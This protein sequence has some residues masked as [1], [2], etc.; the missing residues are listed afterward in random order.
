MNDRSMMR[1]PAASSR[2]STAATFGTSRDKRATHAVMSDPS[3][4]D[5]GTTSV[6]PATIVEGPGA[7]PEQLQ[8][9]AEEELE[10]EPEPEPEQFQPE[11]E[12]EREENPE[13]PAPMITA[14]PRPISMAALRGI[15][16]GN[17]VQISGPP[18]GKSLAA[19]WAGGG[20]STA[21]YT[22][23]PTGYSAPDFE[24]N[25][26]L[27]GTDWNAK[28]TLKTAANEGTSGSF[29]TSAGTHKTGT[30]EGGKDLY[31]KYTAA[32]SNL[33]KVGEQEHCDDYAE[34][35]KISLKEA[36]TIISTKLAGKTFGPKPS[37]VEAEKLVTDEI[38]ANLTHAGLRNDKTKWASIYRT[39]YQKTLSR[40]TSGWHSISLGARTV[41]AVTGDITYEVVKGTSQ[42]GT[43]ASNTIIKY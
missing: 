9:Q 22:D 25:A 13:G 5:F 21:G 19:I 1:R 2:L 31:W 39:L 11:A 12:E 37:K 42:I 8:R 23:W 34:A 33:V 38:T 29:Y 14:E 26:T 7:E 3:G 40:D 17:G 18:V 28:P 43:H 20:A 4:H 41:D 27:T 32:I 10:Q 30:Q 15:A 35:Y 16:Q 36:E 6:Y 24:F